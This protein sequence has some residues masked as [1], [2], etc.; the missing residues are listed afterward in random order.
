M[1]APRNW[2]LFPIGLA[3]IFA[4]T[5]TLPG[6]RAVAQSASSSS[7][8]QAPKPAPP[9][10]SSAGTPDDATS[11][12]PS[13]AD[14]ARTAHAQKDAQKDKPKAKRVYTEDDLAGLH[15]TISV[16]GD[17]SSGSD[18]GDANDSSSRASSGGNNSEAYWR[19]RARAIKEQIADA[20][21]RIAQ[22]KAEIAK[23]G[24]ASFD[25][26]TGLSQGVI[27]I[28][29]RNAQVKQLEDRKASLQRQLDDL[30]DEAR[31]AGADPGWTR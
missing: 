14:A 10:A 23:S 19:S 26:S 16:V 22:I 28:H 5:A 27:I 8:A 7:Q 15:G 20:D 9:P 18:D 11:Q 2:A 25:P 30:A 4:L 21:R 31:K 6:S 24:A 29:D 1:A 12:P 13:L 17:Q 3:F